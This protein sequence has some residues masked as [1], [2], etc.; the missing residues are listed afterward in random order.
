MSTTKKE[1][2]SFGGNVTMEIKG[3][4]GRDI[5]RLSHHSGEKEV[6]FPAGTRFK[7]VSRNEDTYHQSGKVTHFVLEEV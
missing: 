4:S 2:P 7:I 6:L 5:S 3:K 1:S